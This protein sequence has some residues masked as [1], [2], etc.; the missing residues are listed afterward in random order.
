MT[1]IK[2]SVPSIGYGQRVILPKGCCTM[3]VDYMR[4]N[5]YWCIFWGF[6]LQFVGGSVTAMS[7]SLPLIV[8]GWSVCLIGMVLL[9]I[10]F[11][12]YI[13]S[14]GR[15]PAWCLLALLSII[16]WVVLILL[17]DKNQSSL[18]QENP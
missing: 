13:R 12:F 9:L 5:F 11:D 7:H 15:S 18:N 17:K 6:F 1:I 3:I 2:D 4:K 14:K 10:G 16:G 8:L